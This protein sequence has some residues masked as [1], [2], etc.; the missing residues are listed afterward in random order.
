MQAGG[1]AGPSEKP[2]ETTP[3]TT[4]DEPTSTC[5]DC[6]KCAPCR[7]QKRKRRWFRVRLLAGTMLPFLLASLD[8]TVVA[9]ALPFIARHFG[10]TG[11]QTWIVTAYTLTSTAF[12]PAFGQL[13]DVFGR[14]ETLQLAL[15][16]M[17]VGSI[18]CAATHSWPVL[19]LGRALQ[20][21]SAAGINS[22]ITCIL[23]DRLSL[24]E[25]AKV[26]SVVQFVSGTAYCYG[27]VIGGYLTRANWRWC[28]VISIPISVIAAGINFFALR[29][30]LVKGTHSLFRSP[31]A[32]LRSMDFFGTALFV[33]AICLIILAT[34][35]G[36]GYYSWS[37]AAVLVPLILGLISFILFPI[38][39]HLLEPGRAIHKHLPRQSA[40]IPLGLFSRPDITYLVIIQFA[41]GVALY[42]IFYYLAIYYILVRGEPPSNAGL[43][44]LWY[45]AGI[46][47]GV[48]LAILSCNVYPASTFWPIFCGTWAETAG[49][50][51]IAYAVHIESARLLIAMTVV[52]GY[53]TG[54]RFM[55]CSL[56]VNGIWPTKRAQALSLMRFAMPFGGTIG[57]AI[58][59]SV[60]NNKFAEGGFSFDTSSVSPVSAFSGSSSSN[61][62]VLAGLPPAE[63][64][65]IRAQAK[66]AVTWAFISIT[67]ILGLS[68][69]ASLLLGNVW[70]K[71]RAAVVETV[72]STAET[73]GDASGSEKA[74]VVVTPVTP[75]DRHASYVL[76][77]SYILA[78]I[79]G[80]KYM[81]SKRMVWYPGDENAD[82]NNS[83]IA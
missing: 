37:S 31:L 43:E 49:I 74:P 33:T 20:G 67:P 13:A 71:S 5:H 39:E 63:A 25:N 32:G 3:T 69:L 9:T 29:K 80:K 58:M 41:T 77:E 27:P 2:L 56:M 52:T 19:L 12:I 11:E 70:V 48:V 50:A 59:G 78:L 6:G 75:R 21:V 47:T 55:P 60:F 79:R 73:A 44:L 72:E 82:V 17:T 36:G 22:S 61:T 64:D 68:C 10:Q 30:Y 54:T 23:S 16:F 1:A 62:D 35:W 45:I 65:A 76:H 15:A 40:M 7:K 57:L 46:G 14:H 81:E 66:T 26:N 24:Q 42:S 53:G 18:M 4:I 34:T 28:F 51:T 38:Y 83:T 8:L